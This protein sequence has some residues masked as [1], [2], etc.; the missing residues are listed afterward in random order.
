MIEYLP[1][2]HK[3]L[4]SIPNK[5]KKKK[6]VF[7]NKTSSLRYVLSETMEKLSISCSYHLKFNIK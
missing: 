2:M 7:I 6:N 4:D 3:T 1:S 5:Q